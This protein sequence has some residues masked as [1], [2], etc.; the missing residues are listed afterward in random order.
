MVLPGRS[1]FSGVKKVQTLGWD[2]WACR[3]QQRHWFAVRRCFGNFYLLLL[4]LFLS[5]FSLSLLRPQVSCL[6]AAFL[7]FQWKLLEMCCFLKIQ[8]VLGNVAAVSCA[9]KVAGE[10]GIKRLSFN[11]WKWSFSVTVCSFWSIHHSGMDVK[12]QFW[13]KIDK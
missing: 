13:G 5:S 11:Y 7:T 12:W 2:W 4:L 9:F 10:F 3:T 6:T 1:A 8:F